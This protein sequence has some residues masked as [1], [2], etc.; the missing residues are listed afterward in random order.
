LSRSYLL[1]AALVASIGLG[2]LPG[3][4]TAQFSP[5]Q[6]RQL[7]NSIGTRIEALTILGGDFGLSDGSLKSTGSGIGQPRGSADTQLDVTKVGGGGDIGDPQ[8]IGDLGVGWQPRVQGNMGYLESTNHIHSNLLAGDTSTFRDYAIQ[9]GGGARFW[10][11]ERLSLAPTFMGMYGHTTN[12]Y[13]AKS[14][15]MLA[16][17]GRATQLGLIDWRVET[18]TIRPALD[19]QYVL[20][21]DRLIVT[22]SSDPTYFHT[23]SF[24]SSKHGVDFNGNSGSIADKIDIDIPLGVQLYGHELR[25]G[26]YFSRTELLGD[27]KTGLDVRHINEMHGR[28]VLDFLNQLWKVQ[29]IGVGGSYLWGTNIS[30]W[31]VGADVAFRF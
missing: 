26:G 3:T 10:V 9:F 24:R 20:T 18:W 4:A 1:V 28:L 17:M 8:P 12:T 13:S 15:F 2:W 27:L 14:A 31:A 7:R 21:L 29:W 23:E 16:N 5:Q 6:T 19:I 30:G 22:L 11:S 25:T